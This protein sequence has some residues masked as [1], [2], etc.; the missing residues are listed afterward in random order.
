M[1]PHLFHIGGMSLRRTE[2]HSWSPARLSWDSKPEVF[3][4]S[5]DSVRSF[6]LQ[7]LVVVLSL[8]LSV[9]FLIR[10]YQAKYV[11]FKCL[12]SPE[13]VL[14]NVTQWWLGADVPRSS[15]VLSVHQGNSAEAFNKD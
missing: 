14:E 13:G 6:C 11:W 1:S 15:R 3:H 12:L 7:G 4:S 9:F 2:G 8:P 10:N 5:S